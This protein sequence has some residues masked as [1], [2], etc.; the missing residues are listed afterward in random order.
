MPWIR[1]SAAHTGHVPGRPGRI[2]PARPAVPVPA[3]A[4]LPPHRRVGRTAAVRGHGVVCRPGEQG[5]RHGWNRGRHVVSVQRGVGQ[6]RLQAKILGQVVRFV[7]GKLAGRCSIT[8]YSCT[9]VRVNNI[10]LCYELRVGD[11]YFLK[12]FLLTTRVNLN[13]LSFRYCMFYRVP[14][15]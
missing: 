9:R 12:I 7:Q 5:A 4:L 1:P 6:V 13:I 10:V 15:T 2:P 8:I 11:F 14:N 3:P